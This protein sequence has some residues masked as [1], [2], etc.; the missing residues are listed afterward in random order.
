LSMMPWQTTH[1]SVSLFR[2]PRICQRIKCSAMRQGPVLRSWSALWAPPDFSGSRVA[3]QMS[4]S[5]STSRR[6]HPAST[7]PD[8]RRSR[9]VRWVSDLYG[10]VQARE[11]HFAGGAVAEGARH[12]GRSFRYPTLPSRLIAISFCASTANSIGRCCSTSLTKPL[13]TSAV[14]SSADMPRCRQ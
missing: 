5:I 14:A 13:T 7:P 12:R 9:K 2:N 8:D 1:F 11:C 3:F 4:S 10:G 6:A